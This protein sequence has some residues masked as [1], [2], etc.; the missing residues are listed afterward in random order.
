MFK[1][2]YQNEFERNITEKTNIKN[3]FKIALKS[4]WDFKDWVPLFSKMEKSR[5]IYAYLNIKKFLCN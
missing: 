2:Y 3:V 5:V 1:N 4:L